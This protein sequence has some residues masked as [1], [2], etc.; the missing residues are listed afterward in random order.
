MFFP[1]QN[2]GSDWKNRKIQILAK[3]WSLKR[4]LA[5]A[6]WWGCPDVCFC[7][8][9]A[10]LRTVQHTKQLPFCTVRPTINYWTCLTCTL[11][12]FQTELK[13][14]LSVEVVRW[15]DCWR[16]LRDTELK[17]GSS[18][19]KSHQ[20]IVMVIILQTILLLRAYLLHSLHP[21]VMHST[22]QMLMWEVI[23]WRT[24]NLTGMVPI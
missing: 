3:N 4:L 2:W 12:L 13:R 18:V 11:S 24:I 7:H 23:I 5:G 16:R 6:V 9:G 15:S 14:P 8:V 10:K 20:R 21:W 17:L 22:V 1:C 19:H